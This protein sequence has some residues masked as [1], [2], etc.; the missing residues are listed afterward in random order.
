MNFT[1]IGE[2]R[3]W[4]LAN[5]CATQALGA[6]LAR[7]LCRDGGHTLLLSGELG[8]GKT[9][10]VQGLARGLGIDDV[11]TSPTFALSQ[12]YQGSHG[13]LVHLDLY[14]LEQPEAA[15]EL[16]A[17]EQEI[18][19]GIHALLA[20]EWPERL[21]GLPAH[22]WCVDLRLLDPR[23]PDRGRLARIRPPAALP[24]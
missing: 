9:C 15:D 13:A 4:P 24:G 23:D 10:L 20:V 12:H 18:A 2:E 16:L 21:S 17:Q 1:G 3:E 7:T 14:R 22:S 6:E 19:R 11:V 5:A 8:A